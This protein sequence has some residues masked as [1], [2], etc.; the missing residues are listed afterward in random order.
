MRKQGS[1]KDRKQG[2]PKQRK[3]RGRQPEPRE[4]PSRDRGTPEEDDDPETMQSDLDD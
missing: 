4:F 1:S 3:Q 2:A